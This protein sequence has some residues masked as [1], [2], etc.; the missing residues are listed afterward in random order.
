MPVA[1]GPFIQKTGILLNAD[2][3]NAAS[4]VPGSTT[5]TNVFN[6]SIY[7][8]TL[9]GTIAFNASDSKGALVFPAS[10]SYVDFGNIGNLATSWSFQI[11]VKPEP[12]ASGNYTI[13]SYA[14]GLDTG[15]WT[16][17]LDYSSSNQSAVLSVFSS[18]SGTTKI[19]HRVS[20]SVPTSSW[21]IINA[22][23]GNQ[24]LGMYVNG[25]PVDYT[26]TTGSTVGYNFSNRLYLGGSYLVTSSYYTG[27]IGSLFVY[28]SDVPNTQLVQNYNAFAT[29]FG[30]QSSLFFPTSVDADAF[31]FIEVANITNLTQVTAIN[32]LVAEL[33]TNNLWNKMQVIYPFIGGTAYSHKWNLKNPADSDDAF[34]IQ[35]V[36]SVGHSSNGVT[37]TGGYIETYFNPSDITPPSS[38]LH[39]SANIHATSSTSNYY[40]LG[41]AW[42]SDLMLTTGEGTLTRFNS[43]Q[44][45]AQLS[46]SYDKR[47]FYVVSRETVSSATLYR[48]IQSGNFTNTNSNTF[49]NSTNTSIKILNVP[50]KTTY[51]GIV[52]FVTFGSGLSVGET[53]TLNTI[54]RNFNTTLSRNIV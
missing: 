23:Y 14:A 34:R 21:S 35:Y 44:S 16:Y 36:G 13:L 6:P 47:G 12:S 49:S 40:L 22:S 1:G 43:F 11:A 31:K 15:S 45:Y 24:V 5:I 17:K 7:N 37:S 51:D 53:S 38:S 30:L 29:R 50:S 41:N 32:N 27:S 2:A 48:Y 25:R 18:G 39:F 20:G 42:L 33:K 9:N 54:V 26:V 3:A 52:N 19:V 8:G 28:N 4:Y 46:D 10:N